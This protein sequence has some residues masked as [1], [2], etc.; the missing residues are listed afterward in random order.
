MPFD[1][2]ELGRSGIEACPEREGDD[3]RDE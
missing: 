1:E 2:L 3:E